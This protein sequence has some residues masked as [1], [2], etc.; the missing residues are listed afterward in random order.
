MKPELAR[1][2]ERLD[3][4]PEVLQKHPQITPVL[5]KGMG[6][7]DKVIEC[8]RGSAAKEAIELLKVWDASTKKDRKLV[9][10][11]AFC[12]AAKTTPKVMIGIIMQALIVESSIT[13][14]MLLA[15]AHAEVVKTT[16]KL[17]KKTKGV[18]ERKVILQNRGTLPAPKNQ[19]F[20]NYGS[21]NQDN[22]KQTAVSVSQLDD[23]NDKI[24]EAVDGFNARRQ[25]RASEPVEAEVVEE[26]N[27]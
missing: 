14:E 11:E 19:I 18:D 2:L 27:G 7:I 16:I 5:I 13:T 15:S 9:C 21:L 12:L 6:S 26:D 1:A 22:R 24:G 8:L 17:A 4:D 10:F 23:D 20:N 25:I 3:V